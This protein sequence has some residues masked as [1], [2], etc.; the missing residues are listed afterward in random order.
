M[1][2]IRIGIY[3]AGFMAGIHAKSMQSIEGAEVVAVTGASIEDAQNFCKEQAPGATGFDS[4]EAMLDGAELDAV[5]FCIPPYLHKGEVELAAGRGLH[6]FLE[7][8]IALNSEAAGS[9]VEAI[10]SAGVVSQVGFMMRFRKSIER[11]K[12]RIDS[13]EAGRATLF[14][15]RFWV[16][17]DGS[18]WWRNKEQSG[19]QVFE[20]IIHLYDLAAYLFGDVAQAKGAIANLLHSDQSDY[21][22]EDTSVGL[23]QFKNGALA[24][25]TGSNSAVPMHFFADFRVATEND[26]LEYRCT[27]Q[28][29]VEPDVAFSYDAEG[30]KTEI[31]EDGDPFFEEDVH[32]ID[33]IR[34]GQTTRCPARDG[35]RAIEIV[36]AMLQSEF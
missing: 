4:F 23:L 2:T 35:L 30:N 5:Y 12:A 18:P 19:G 31:A 25:I 28:P 24:S 22:I 3:G 13:G 16:N 6:V 20:Q 34:S 8:P 21:T 27:G 32:F 14:T 33:C 7:K 10:E 36:E 9:M 15:G 29:W 17:M 11:L 1:K 26:T